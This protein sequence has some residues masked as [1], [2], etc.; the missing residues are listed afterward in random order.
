MS[1]IENAAFNR[2]MLCQRLLFRRGFILSTKEQRDAIRAYCDDAEKFVNRCFESGCAYYADIPKHFA[3]V[4]ETDLLRRYAPP[5]GCRFIE[6]QKAGDD[7]YFLADHPTPFVVHSQRPRK[8]SLV[9]DRDESFDCLVQYRIVASDVPV[10][11]VWSALTRKRHTAI[12]PPG[13]T[14]SVTKIE[15]RRTKKTGKTVSVFYVDVISAQ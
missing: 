8:T 12:L 1:T 13:C 9:V 10:L 4:F 6:Y 7:F 5:T 3:S 14:F 2:W 15:K 11:C